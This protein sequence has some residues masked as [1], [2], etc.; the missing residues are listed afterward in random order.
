MCQA[1][2]VFHGDRH[3][4]TPPRLFGDAA[5][6]DIR[7]IEERAWTPHGSHLFS[8]APGPSAQVG[9]RHAQGAWVTQD[10]DNVIKAWGNRLARS[11]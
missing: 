7:G 9:I 2:C 4:A 8:E 11:K 5:S 3:E 10:G 1:G 6:P